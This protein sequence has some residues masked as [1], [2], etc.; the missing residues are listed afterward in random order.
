MT[1]EASGAPTA[2]IVALSSPGT[3]RGAVGRAVLDAVRRRAPA[4]DVDL[5]EVEDTPALLAAL[6]FA[7]PVVVV[8]ALIGGAEGE[9]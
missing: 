5:C 2:R 4:P 1:E 9:V 3:P 8:D 7:G 6:R